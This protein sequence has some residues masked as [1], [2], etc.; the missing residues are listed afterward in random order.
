[1][2]L[3]QHYNFN[4]KINNLV[5]KLNNNKIYLNISINNYILLIY[6]KLVKLNYKKSNKN[7]N[8]KNNKN[9]NNNTKKIYHQ[10]HL[11]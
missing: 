9:N 5:N 1:M 2:I 6:K 4:I 7:N 10:K 11:Q 3:K 8:K